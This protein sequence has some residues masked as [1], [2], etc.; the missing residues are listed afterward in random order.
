[1]WIIAKK[2]KGQKDNKSTNPKN[3]QNCIDDRNA[4]RTEI[5]ETQILL[6]VAREGLSL[7]EQL[8]P[9]LVSNTAVL[10]SVLSLKIRRNKL[11]KA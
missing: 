5:K 3:F 10:Y 2:T 9:R 7:S 11:T 4:G 1:M 8:I 6:A